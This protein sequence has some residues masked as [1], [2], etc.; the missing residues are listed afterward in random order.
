MSIY[1]VA[2]TGAGARLLTQAAAGGGTLTFT[3]AQL[4]SGIYTGELSGRT[5][6]VTPVCYTSIDTPAL[7]GDVIR[8][9]VL[10][11]NRADGGGYMAGFTI[12]EIGLWARLADGAETLLAYAN[13]GA[14]ADG[15]SVPG[16]ALTEFTYIFKIRFSGAADVTMSAEGVD[17][18]TQEALASGLAG[19][20]DKAHTHAQADI[21]GLADALAGKAD[22]TLTVTAKATAAGWTGEAAPYTQVIAVTGM[23]Q[24]C[25][26]V[27]GLADTATQEQRKAC[28]EAMISPAGQAAG[29]VTLVADGRKPEVDLP[30][31]IMILG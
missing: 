4:G 30:V 20:A 18:V 17:Y 13:A 25:S 15:I 3:R 7:D 10:F 11:T 26:A 22:A 23:T 5:G 12:N 29:T 31:V 6:L 27:V 28:R 21:T 19:K 14:E 24:A 1:G 16:D 8:V 2:V 9:P